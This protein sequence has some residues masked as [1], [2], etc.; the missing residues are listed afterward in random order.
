MTERL[1][2]FCKWLSHAVMALAGA[3]LV[4]ITAI[5]TWQVFA[6]YVLN[7]SPAWTEQAALL[8]LVWMIFLGGAA[9]VHQGFH[10]RLSLLEESCPEPWRRWLRLCTQALV[11]LFGLTM[12]V[13]GAGL[14]MATMGHE[15]PALGVSRAVTYI[16]VAISGAL[17]ALFSLDRAIAIGLNREVPAWN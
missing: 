6:R 14:G 3:C 12:A 17:I 16:P 11:I 4:A 9:G 5:I 8:V 2:L 13:C 15:L 1:S 7:N 10:L